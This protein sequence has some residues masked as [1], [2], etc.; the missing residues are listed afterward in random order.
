M[1]PLLELL[2]G[3]LYY[4]IAGKGPTLVLVSGLGGTTHYWKNIHSRLD[5]PSH[6]VGDSA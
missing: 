1:M 3:E 6:G 5:V 4:E 2:D